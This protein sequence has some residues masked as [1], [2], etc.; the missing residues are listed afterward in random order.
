MAR[1]WS[2]RRILVPCMLMFVS[3]ITIARNAEVTSLL[4]SALKEKSVSESSTFR[5]QR[6]ERAGSNG[7]EVTQSAEDKV[8][9][10]D[11]SSETHMM[12]E[13]SNVYHPR[14]F[15]TDGE[16]Q[17]ASNRRIHIDRDILK[18]W[19]HI[20]DD[21][22]YPS[23][24][25]SASTDECISV[26]SWEADSYPNCNSI[27]EVDLSGAHLQGVL[28]FVASGGSNDVFQLHE[29]QNASAALYP[30]LVVKML[31]PGKKHL[32]GI[33]HTS[34]YSKSNL[35]VVRR[36]ALVSE[37]LTRSA[38]VQS[39]L[40]YC[41]F[42][43]VMPFADGGALAKILGSEYSRRT[44][45]WRTWTPATR[46]KYAVEAASGLADLHDIGVVH[47]DLTVRQYMLRNGVLELGDF[48]RGIFLRKNTT[49]SVD[50]PCTFLMTDNYGVTRAP[51]EYMHKPQTMAVDVWSL[52][53]I[54]YHLLTGTKVWSDLKKNQAQDAVIQ[55]KLPHV[56]ER[57][58]ESSDPVDKL[59]LEA[60]HMCSI[61]E[62]SQRATAREVATILKNGLERL[63]TQS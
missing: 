54:L 22:K 62:P 20:E 1:S 21:K 44:K 56:S 11:G 12:D 51:E 43:V 61:Y 30:D 18:T 13:T 8:Y 36:D 5:H 10:Y 31:S 47:A 49:A 63:P 9:H 46:L 4:S 42:S 60:F 27:H 48:N 2:R 40:G 23:E 26:S 15:Y 17:V 37:R 25:N 55:G 35:D 53:S 50:I 39:L 41:G 32:P 45:L 58:L 52:G 6:D 14:V 38:H 29:R 3:L 57:F 16:F 34:Q 28:S 59:L 19:S 7:V 33:P 24:S